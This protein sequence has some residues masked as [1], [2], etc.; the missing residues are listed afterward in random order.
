[1]FRRLGVGH[2][3]YLIKL[4]EERRN[5]MFELANKYGISSEQTIECSQKL[6][7]LLNLLM[8][9]KEKRKNELVR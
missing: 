6:D 4:I 7:S 3:D 8:V 9:E 5:K 2:L 1:M